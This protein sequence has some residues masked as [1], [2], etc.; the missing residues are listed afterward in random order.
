M[1]GNNVV[2][3]RIGSIN[4]KPKVVHDEKFT[5]KSEIIRLHTDNPSIVD[6][7]NSLKDVPIVQDNF[8][9]PEKPYFIAGIRN[10]DRAATEIS[11][12]DL[13]EDNKLEVNRG[14]IST[15][16][17]YQIGGR[18]SLNQL[19]G[20]MNIPS[21]WSTSTIIHIVSDQIFITRNSVYLIWTLSDIRN[22]RL[23]LILN[24]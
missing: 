16:T 4:D 8:L 6:S 7:F 20:G 13:G 21:F 12:L 14:V 18:V 5:G 15:S 1:I 24:G 10:F 2:L 11:G 23:K 22:E 19:K 3:I 17:A 9:F